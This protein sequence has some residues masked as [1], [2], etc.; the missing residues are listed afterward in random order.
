MAWDDDFSEKEIR[1]H[2]PYGLNVYK[3]P[4]VSADRIYAKDLEVRGI[5]QSRILKWNLEAFMLGMRKRIELKRKPFARSI[6]II[7]VWTE[8]GVF[9]NKEK[10]EHIGYMPEEVAAVIADT[11]AYGHIIPQLQET[12]LSDKGLVEIVFRL[13]GPRKGA[14]EFREKLEEEWR[15]PREFKGREGQKAPKRPSPDSSK[16]SSKKQKSSWLSEP[17]KSESSGCMVA[18]GI[19]VI[20]VVTLWVMC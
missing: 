4:A 20:F 16:S 11:G 7:G 12:Y 6:E 3:H 19:I 13:I 1:D 17:Q 14:K 9:G 15:N 18:L 5:A 8:L 10:R 2:D